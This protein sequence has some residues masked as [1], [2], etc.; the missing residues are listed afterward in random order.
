MKAMSSR[1][2]TKDVDDLIILI[3]VAGI[4]TVQEG[5]RLVF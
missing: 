5:I 1:V 4:N 2:G 3:K